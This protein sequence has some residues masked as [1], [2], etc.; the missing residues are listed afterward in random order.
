MSRLFRESPQ[1][2]YGKGVLGYCIE[3]FLFAFFWSL[4]YVFGIVMVLLGLRSEL[5]E[6]MNVVV[7]DDEVDELDKM[8]QKMN[9]MGPNN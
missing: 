7:D 3:F 8:V 2:P 4:G 6:A 9:E 5:E 1:K